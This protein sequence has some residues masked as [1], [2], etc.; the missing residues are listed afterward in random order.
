[1]PSAPHTVALDLGGTDLKAACISAAGEVL[2]FARMPSRASEG[3][4]ALMDTLVGAAREWR[5]GAVAVGM[6]CPGVIHPETGA[7]VDE[8]PHLSLPRDFALRD[9]LARALAL[10]VE[11]DND[12]NCAALGEQR[13]G[14]ARGAR[15]AVVVTVGTGIGCG[16]VLDG[17]VLR[18]AWG[19]AGEIAHMGQ[20][21]SGPACRCGVEGCAE[22]VSG[23]EGVTLRARAAGLEAPD[24]EA[25]F[26]L[27]AAGEPTATRLVAEMADALGLQLACA[28]QTV[29]PEVLVIGGG[30]SQAGEALFAPVRDA[31]ARYTQPSHRRHLSIVPARLGNRA[32]VVGAGL[33]AWDRAMAKTVDRRS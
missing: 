32:G 8:T 3:F 25:V 19:G 6:G 18:G 7:L 16:I 9:A 24:A 4:D 29:N 10:P 26:A 1:M 11:V 22:P 20:A 13:T 28:I 23:G 33:M 5:A 31:V 2:E 14:A 27:A 12:A 15:V 17:R 30:V 21:C